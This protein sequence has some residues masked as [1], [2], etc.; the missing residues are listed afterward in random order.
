MQKVTLHIQGMT[1]AA[2]AKAVERAAMKA[3][4]ASADVNMATEK[5]VVTY[6]DPS[7]SLARIK[8]AIS[9]AGYKA[10]NALTDE[11]QERRK[12]RELAELKI[13]LLIAA[14]FGAPLLYVAMA[15]MITFA[16]LPLP[17]AIR[18]HAHP[19]AY[20]LFELALTLPIIAAGYRFYY[21]GFRAIFMGNP[22]MDSLVAMGTSAAFCYSV[23]S[24]ARVM[25]GYAEAAHHLYF[26]SA[27]VIIALILLG[28]T[29]E[30]VSKGRTSEAVK[31]LV[32]LAPKTARVVG[33]DGTERTVPVEDV[34]VGDIFVIRPGENLPVDGEITD[35]RSS[36]DESMLTGESMPVEKLQGDPVYAATLNQNGAMVCRA[37]KVGEDTALAQIVR[38]VRDAQGSKAPIAK[39]ADKVSGIF[40]PVVFSIASLSALAWLIAGRD[41][42]FAL[43]IFISVLVIACP[44]ALGLATPTAIMVGTGRA[45][46]LGVLVRS[47]AALEMLGRVTTVVLDKTGTVTQGKPVVTDVFSAEGVTGDTL[48]AIAASA[49]SLSEHPLGQAVARH[50]AEKGVRLSRADAFEAVP[51]HGIRAIVDGEPA[52]VGNAGFVGEICDVSVLSGV[53]SSLASKGKTPMFV[54]R[55]GRLL[56]LIAVS[57]AIKP[58]SAQA[59]REMRS[60]GLEVVIMT[61][62]NALAAKSIA[63]E[64]GVSRV[65]AEVLPGDKAAEVATMMSNGSRVAMVGDGINDAPALARADIGIAVGTGTDVAIESA[66]VILSRGDLRGVPMAVLLGRATMR[67]IKQNLF[68]A[69]AYNVLGIPVAAGLLYALGGPLLNPMIAAAAM[70]L[71]SVSVVTNALRLKTYRT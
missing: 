56:G 60:A 28:K 52:R 39:L 9:N 68:W 37:T 65:L 63:A 48:L 38:M 42:E 35:G 15:P 54:A 12:G 21:V 36:V 32:K 18:P 26:E 2:C 34:R 50:A 31:R 33:A 70:S 7:V 24:V 46:E 55:G 4:A 8:Q 29:L 67:V 71:S 19:L 57:D 5:L 41:I 13:K 59:V 6:E 49:E 16:S 58:T 51:G 11:E 47:G 66:D 43:T 62:D 64:A 45:A 14:F 27:G 17:A 22:T 30:A 20:A 44:C 61:G 69:F 40:V 3:G 25:G 53:A 10:V 23:Y 1:C